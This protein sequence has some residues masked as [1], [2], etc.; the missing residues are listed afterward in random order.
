M[1]K[2]MNVTPPTFQVLVI[3]EDWISPKVIAMMKKMNYE[4]GTGLEKKKTGISE[5]PYFK[6]ETSQQGLV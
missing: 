3:N 4:L 2:C 5:L 6:G 1:V